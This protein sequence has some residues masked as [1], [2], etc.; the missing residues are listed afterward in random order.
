[1][2]ATRCDNLGIGQGESSLGS[3]SI[4]GRQL[5]SDP[6]AVVFERFASD[7][8]LTTQTV[9][10]AMAIPSTKWDHWTIAERTIQR[11]QGRKLIVTVK[12]PYSRG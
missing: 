4:A 12:P 9:K 2:I 5:Q 1:L 3:G 8:W 6:F 10:N 7:A 11:D